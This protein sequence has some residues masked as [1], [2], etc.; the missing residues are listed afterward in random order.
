LIADEGRVAEARALY[1]HW[2]PIIQAVFGQ[3]FVSGTKA[4]LN[5]MGFPAGLPRPPRLPLPAAR[6]AAMGEMVRAF[7]LR[8]PD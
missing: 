7:G 5:H 3:T 2:L 4:L 1:W 8:F 6:D